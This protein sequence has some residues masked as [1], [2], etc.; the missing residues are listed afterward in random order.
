MFPFNPREHIRG[1]WESIFGRVLC[2]KLPECIFENFEI[3]KF[4]KITRVIY[5]Q[6][7]PKQTS[8][9]WLIKPNKQTFCIETNTFNSGQLQISDRA[10][11]KLHI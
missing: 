8:D 3:S 10:I 2:D 4:S 7:C 9:D 6:N 1:Q 5:I 11:K